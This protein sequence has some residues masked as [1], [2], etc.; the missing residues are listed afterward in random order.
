MRLVES[1]RHLS[2]NSH[3]LVDRKRSGCEVPKRLPLDVLH[4]NESGAVAGLSRLIN[5]GDVRM[6]EFRSGD[7]LLH[8]AL[9]RFLVRPGQ[10]FQRNL[11]LQSGIF[12]EVNLPHPAAADLPDH[13]VPPDI[14]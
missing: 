9:S 4:R 8:K 6:R 7:R 12:R 1:I 13:P 2:R 3:D 5:D 10:D 14:V 11:P